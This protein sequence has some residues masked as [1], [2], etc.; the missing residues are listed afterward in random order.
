MMSV[1]CVSKDLYSKYPLSGRVSRDGSLAQVYLKL[2]AN[3]PSKNNGSAQ[4]LIEVSAPKP[5]LLIHISC[6]DLPDGRASDSLLVDL[7]LRW[8]VGTAVSRYTRQTPDE[9]GAGNCRITC[10]SERRQLPQSE[11]DVVRC[12]CCTLS[13]RSVKVH[14]RKYLRSDVTHSAQWMLVRCALC[15]LRLPDR[16]IAR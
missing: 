15:R 11:R 6:W 8:K 14:W 9:R 4:R 13:S 3:C 7:E 5:R 16:D 10:L 12:R 2:S 1:M